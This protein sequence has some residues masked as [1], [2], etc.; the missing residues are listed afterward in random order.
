MTPWQQQPSPAWEEPITFASRFAGSDMALFYSGLRERFTG[1]FSYLFVAPQEVIEGD[2]WAA[3]P[4]VEDDNELP[5]WVGYL[6]Y[7]LGDD[8]AALAP[9]FIN[10]PKLRLIR[11]GQLFRFNHEEKK[12]DYFSHNTGDTISYCVPIALPLPLPRWER[13]HGHRHPH[14]QLHSREL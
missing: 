3:L 7:E 4:K 12:I 8:T 14:L 2:D 5:Q 9:S 6:G 11:Y 10:L 1:A 13:E